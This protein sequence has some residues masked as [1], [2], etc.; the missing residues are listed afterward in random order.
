MLRLL[1]KLTMRTVTP[2]RAFHHHP[3]IMEMEM[4]RVIHIWPAYQM[5]IADPNISSTLSMKISVAERTQR[6]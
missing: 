6:Y 5:V 3:M 1:S 4:D 2:V